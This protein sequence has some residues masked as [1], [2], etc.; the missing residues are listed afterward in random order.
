MA[1][2]SRANK[3]KILSAIYDLQAG[4]STNGSEGIRLAYERAKENSI[5]DGVNR[6]IL[7]TDGDFNV[8]VF[9]RSELVKLIEK[10]RDSGM[11][12]SVL[13]V[14]AR[15]N[16]NPTPKSANYAVKEKKSL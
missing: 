1:P 14:R 16:T 7:A 10:K 4:G 9:S 15:P 11:Y 5:R 6:V 8:G 2:T 3:N 12:L 13:G